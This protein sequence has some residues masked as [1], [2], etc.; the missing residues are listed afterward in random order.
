MPARRPAAPTPDALVGAAYAAERLGVDVKTVARYADRGVLPATRTPGGHRRYR[1]GD[2]DELAR[3][4]RILDSPD[5]TADEALAALTFV[6]DVARRYAEATEPAP[7]EQTRADGEA[8]LARVLRGLKARAR[9]YRDAELPPDVV[10]YL[11]RRLARFERAADAGA[12][13]VL[14][15]DECARSATTIRTVLGILAPEA[16]EPASDRPAPPAA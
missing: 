16:L 9:L 4:L 1:A 8:L 13:C 15:P 5:A 6:R 7:L 10:D 14:E 11:R 12:R 2:V 3:T